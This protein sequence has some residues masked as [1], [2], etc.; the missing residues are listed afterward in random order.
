MENSNLIPFEGKEI[1]KVWH[2][3]QWYFSI[4][5]IIE[6]LTDTDNPSRYWQ[7]L[8][9][10]STKTEGQLYDFIVKLKFLAPDSKMRPTDCANT[11]GIFRIVM[12]VPSP[13][14]EPLRMWLAE[15]GA[16]TL[17]ETANPEL[18]TQRQIELYKLKGYSDEWIK[19]RISSIESRNLLTDEWDK[20]GVKEGK[21]FS[22]LTAIIAKGTFG[23]TPT[24]H[25]DIKGLTKS[26]Q[27]LRDN[28]TRLELIFASLGEETTRQLAIE[29]DAQG[30]EENKD[31]ATKGGKASGVVL[32]TYEAETG[33]KVV[34]TQNFLKASDETKELPIDSNE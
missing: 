28:M 26:S 33:L 9:R 11:D 15:Q 12:S 32:K 2:N 13:K 34:S 10:K 20:R 30:F 19:E 4:I 1:R 27:N 6:I 23:L 21:E 31:K 14:A 18:L 5:D 8:K 17:E 16:R 25:R 29:D 3:E 22:I 7:D 24:E